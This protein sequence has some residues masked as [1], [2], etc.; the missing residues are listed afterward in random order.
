MGSGNKSPKVIQLIGTGASIEC[1]LPDFK[2][3][4]VEAVNVASGDRLEWFEGMTNAHAVKTLGAT[5]AVSII[6]SLGITIRDKGFT[7]GADTDVNV[8]GEALRV[9]CF[10]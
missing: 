1:D 3:R 5:G 8:A 2:P 10:E 9:V 4:I 6:T 7:L